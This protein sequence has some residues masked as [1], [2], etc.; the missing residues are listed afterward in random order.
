MRLFFG[1]QISDIDDV[2]EISL[3][4]TDATVLLSLSTVHIVLTTH[5][6]FIM[7]QSRTM[8]KIQPTLTKLAVR[9]VS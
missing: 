1:R 8:G 5:W 7:R 4:G 6:M 3:D 9:I 2:T